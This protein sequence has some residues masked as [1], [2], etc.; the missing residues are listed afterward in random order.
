MADSRQKG[1]RGEREFCTELRLRGYGAYRSAQHAGIA[2]RDDSA[3]V[4]TSLQPVRFEVKRGFN[5]RHV[6]H[7]SVDEWVETARDETPVSKLWCVAWRPDR[8]DW[9]CF[10]PSVIFSCE[11]GFTHNARWVLVPG[12]DATL[13][14]FDP[15]DNYTVTN[16]DDW[17]L[18]R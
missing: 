3:D 15:D 16:P 13:N 18:R 8:A 10:V 2:E 6:W 7:R 12:L 4:I 5:T 11:D 9:F 17:V 14:L 1:K